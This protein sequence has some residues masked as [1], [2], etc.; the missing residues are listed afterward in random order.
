MSAKQVA[1]RVI[2][3]SLLLPAGVALGVAV[4]KEPL[5]VLG[6]LALCGWVLAV[7]WAAVVVE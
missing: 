2:L 5:A 6:A 7:V 4:S 3:A 1:A